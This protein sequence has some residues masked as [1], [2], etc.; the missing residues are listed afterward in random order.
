[1]RI[2]I[3]AG[4]RS[5][6]LLG[7]ST[8][9]PRPWGNVRSCNTKIV[10]PSNFFS[11][12]TNTSFDYLQRL[13]GLLLG[14]AFVRETPSHG[15]E[16]QITDLP[17]GRADQL[18][19]RIGNEKRPLRTLKRYTRHKCWEIS[20]SPLNWASPR[21]AGGAPMHRGAPTLRHLRRVRLATHC[22]GAWTICET[23]MG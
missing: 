21:T 16:F 15:E 23:R 11:S 18:Q 7:P 8:G 13:A 5:V 4:G 6:L 2:R 17:S 1:M 20:L 12:S 22:D 19:R 9:K 10:V 3:R 14:K